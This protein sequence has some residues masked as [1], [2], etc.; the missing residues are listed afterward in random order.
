MRNAVILVGLIA[1]TPIAW[2]DDVP[3]ADKVAR[4]IAQV[5]PDPGIQNEAR[6]TLAIRQM[7]SARLAAMITTATPEARQRLIEDWGRDRVTHLERTAPSVRV[8][9]IDRLLLELADH[10]GDRALPRTAFELM[11]I[12]TSLSSNSSG[13]AYHTNVEPLLRRVSEMNPDR[14]AR[15]VASF[16]LAKYEKGLAQEVAALKLAPR[17]VFD[18]WVV[19]LGEERA[20]QLGGLDPSTLNADAERL[21]KRVVLDYADVRDPISLRPLDRQAELILQELR[22]PA[23]GRAAPEIM[24]DDVDGKPMKLSD[25]RG[26]VVLLNFGCHET[27][28][29]C[30]ALYPYEKTLSKRLADEPFALLGFDVDAN[31]K[32]LSEAMRAE[33]ITWRSWYENGKGP[34]A[35]LW[36]SEGIPL[37]YLIDHEGV[38]H[39]RY[40]FFP[41]KNVLDNAIEMLLKRRRGTDVQK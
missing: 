24:G 30:R 18:Y 8:V 31:P 26:K 41:G 21:L 20:G 37:L 9:E 38:I 4:R 2:G 11:A 28:G 1:T 35:G 10:A 32:T 12:F 40:V 27:C 6:W 34:I 14:Q 15:A 13:K 25:F 7:E 23:V 19:R 33:G 3:A 36:V 29:P 16:S 17:E 22:G 39:A 5:N